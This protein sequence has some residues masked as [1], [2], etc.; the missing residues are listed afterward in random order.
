MVDKKKSTEFNQLNLQL[1]FTLF[2]K[3]APQPTPQPSYIP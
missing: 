1:L 3:Y 2:I